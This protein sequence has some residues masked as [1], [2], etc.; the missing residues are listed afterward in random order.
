MAEIA[1]EAIGDVAVTDEPCARE[2]QTL[3]PLVDFNDLLR[4]R[5]V[6]GVCSDCVE[7]VE[8]MPLVGIRLAVSKPVGKRLALGR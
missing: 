2:D 6:S 8:Q 3:D 7:I 4:N 1:D 5:S